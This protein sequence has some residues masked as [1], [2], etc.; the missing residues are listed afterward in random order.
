MLIL[1]VA[2][3]LLCSALLAGCTTTTTTGTTAT[4]SATTGVQ[5]TSG[6]AAG[7]ATAIALTAQ[8][9]KFDKTTISVPTGAQVTL[10]LNNMDSGVPHN[11]ALY[12]DASAGTTIFKGQIVNGPGT[13]TYT[14]TAPSTPGTYFFRCDVHPTTMTGSFIVT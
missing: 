3:L 13:V 8:N 6:G 10:T 14:F 11:F 1:A 12:T 5:T 9:V 2:G 7:Q 4:T